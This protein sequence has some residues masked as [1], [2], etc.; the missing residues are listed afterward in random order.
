MAGC[1]R[2]PARS[3]PLMMSLVGKSERPVERLLQAAR[4]CGHQGLS[5][6][7]F[8]VTSFPSRI[9]G[10]GARKRPPRA[11][12]WRGGQL[13][14]QSAKTIDHP[15]EGARMPCA[16]TAPA[17]PRAPCSAGTRRQRALIYHLTCL[18][19]SRLTARRASGYST[20]S[21]KRR[22]PSPSNLCSA[23]FN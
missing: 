17:L 20:L 9:S 18:I 21:Y 11:P 10:D 12:S 6:C 15:S 1:T 3:R 22:I 13:T 2:S 5:A 14:S 16:R 19:R 8:T 23:T 4:E 7:G